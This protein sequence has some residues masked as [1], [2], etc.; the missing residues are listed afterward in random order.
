MRDKTSDMA[1]Y[2]WELMTFQDVRGMDK[3]LLAQQIINKVHCLDKEW[4]TETQ[5]RKVKEE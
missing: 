4:I 5:Q 2:L 1:L 3:Y